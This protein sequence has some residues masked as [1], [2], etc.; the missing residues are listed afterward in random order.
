M[1]LKCNIK[2][3]LFLLD[4]NFGYSVTQEREDATKKQIE[5]E[6]TSKD[7]ST[8]C[9][10]DIILLPPCVSWL[11]TLYTFSFAK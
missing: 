7:W 9:D 10:I 3:F 5:E 6:L 2:I 8:D 1:Q 11:S 4:V